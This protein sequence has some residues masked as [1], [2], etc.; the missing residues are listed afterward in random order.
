MTEVR[1]VASGFGFPEGPV[2]IPDGA[3]ILTEIAGR[4]VTRIGLDGARSTVGSAGGGPNG[5]AIGPDGALYVCNN[6]GGNRPVRPM[7]G[8]RTGRR[9]RRRVH[10][11][12]RSED[13]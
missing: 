2:V 4:C 8:G 3:V 9:L 13:R 5:L 6:G 11:A 10:P 7:D 12:D 1:I